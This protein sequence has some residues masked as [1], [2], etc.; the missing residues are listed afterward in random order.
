M[1]QIILPAVDT[2]LPYD[3]PLS[4][5]AFMKTALASFR[6]HCTRLCEIMR[7]MWELFGGAW[8]QPPV[9]LVPVTVCR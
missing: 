6:T 1:P 3:I 2:G 9:F 5:R 8:L 7:A 4:R